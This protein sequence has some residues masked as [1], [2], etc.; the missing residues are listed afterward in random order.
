MVYVAPVSRKGIVMVVRYV[1]FW[2]KVGVGVWIKVILVRL[3]CW[4]VLH[5]VMMYAWK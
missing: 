5:C 4:V 1:I 2:V 3:V